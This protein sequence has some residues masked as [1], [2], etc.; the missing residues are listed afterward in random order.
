[1]SNSTAKNSENWFST[2]FDSP[3][4]HILYKNRN[5][6]EAQVF[7]NAKILFEKTTSIN[8]IGKEFNNEELKILFN[9]ALNIPISQKQEKS[10]KNEFLS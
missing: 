1:M 9:S 10:M 5:E 8:K 4:Y 7:M 2:W 3:Y 6:E